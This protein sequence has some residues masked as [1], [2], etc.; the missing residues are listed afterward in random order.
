MLRERI[1]FSYSGL[2]TM[3]IFDHDTSNLFRAI[4]NSRAIMV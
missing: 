4:L 1:Y 2:V 3:N